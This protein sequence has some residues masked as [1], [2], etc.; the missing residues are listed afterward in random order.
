MSPVA[1][2]IIPSVVG[3]TARALEPLEADPEVSALPLPGKPGGGTR[4]NR[5]PLSLVVS[6]PRRSRAPF[7]VIFFTLLVAALATVLVINVSVSQGQYTLVALKDQQTALLKT[8]QDLE[9]KLGSQ[10]APQNLVARAKDLGMV[11]AGTTGQIDVRTKRVSGNPQ[12]AVAGTKG[13]A[14]IPP[15]SIDNPTDGD[16]VAAPPAAEQTLKEEAPKQDVP[17]ASAAQTQDLNGGT[18]PAPAQKAG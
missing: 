6:T 18:I 8:N 14:V 3:N 5:T 1:S 10:Q 17:S 2:R 9:Q 4:K 13:L 16:P 7:V 11:P 12:P 15:P